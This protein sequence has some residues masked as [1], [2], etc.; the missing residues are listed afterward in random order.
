[1]KIRNVEV[2]YLSLELT[3]P[4]TIAYETFDKAD[5]IFI[6]VDTGEISGWGCMAPDAQVTGEE[7]HRIF[8]EA[9]RDL[10]DLLRGS[11]ALRRAKIMDRVRS[12]FPD[13]SSLHA[14][15]DMALWDIL[16][17]KAG[18][19]IW[20]ILGGYR[21]RIETSMTIGICSVEDTLR[22]AKM[23]IARGFR[24]LKIKGGQVLEED[25]ER[26]FKLRERFG[27]GIRL[28]FDANQGYS[29]PQALTFIDKIRP[30]NLELLEQPTRQGEPEHLGMVK[31]QSTVPVMADESLV[32]LI[33]AF[34]L[35]KK[36]LVDLINIKIMKV[37][38]IGEAIQ[39]DS[40]ARSA[41]IGVMVGCMDESALSISAG[42][43]FALSRKNIRYA[44]LDGHL[45]LLDDPAAGTVILKDGHLF[46]GDGPGLG[47][48]R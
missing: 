41:K 30:V 46:P 8:P 40:V 10:P 15:V 36:G 28:R 19:P 4:Y 26:L 45:D 29:Y 43:Q 21:S 33:D 5:H 6:R 13:Y 18:L 27:S 2:E 9:S 37:G 23:H 16:G 38:G 39:V 25:L 14:A 32:S 20:K 31:N 17:K 34:K 12:Q 1:M 22:Y 24:I 7:A 11:D 44:D 47:W 42:L 3:N 48:D 35:A